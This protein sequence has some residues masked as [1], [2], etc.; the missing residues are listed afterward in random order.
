MQRVKL[1]RIDRRILF[2]L[3]DD[4]RMTNVEL[5]RRAG[6]S[7]RHVRRL[8]SEPGFRAVWRPL[9]VEN[10]RRRARE[11]ARHLMQRYTSGPQN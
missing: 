6:I 10:S 1:D 2:E 3:Q 7:T 11:I 9:A 4:G 5:A 8:M